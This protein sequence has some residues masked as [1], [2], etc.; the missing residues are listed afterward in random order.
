MITPRVQFPFIISFQRKNHEGL[1]VDKTIPSFFQNMGEELKRLSLGNEEKL[2]LVLKKLVFLESALD[3]LLEEESMEY[4]E[5]LSFSALAEEKQKMEKFFIGLIPILD[6]LDA[7]CRSASESEEPELTRGLEMLKGKFFRYL[8]SCGI[9]NSAEAGMKFDPQF[10]EAV[11]TS[12]SSMKSGLISE[13]IEQ[14][15]VLNGKVM[16]FAKVTVAK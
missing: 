11:G 9:T 6:S 5:K 7:A 16:R 4:D 14:G 1:S 2:S 12:L 10:H 15:W 8:S 13:T 3:E